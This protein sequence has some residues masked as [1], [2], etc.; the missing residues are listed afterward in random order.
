MEEKLKKYGWFE[1]CPGET[2][3]VFVKNNWICYVYF[4]GKVILSRC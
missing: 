3:H 1:L 2:Y 4:S